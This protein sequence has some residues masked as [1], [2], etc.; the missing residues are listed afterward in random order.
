MIVAS[1][2]NGKGTTVLSVAPDMSVRDAARFLRDK[3]IGATVVLD[4]NRKLVGI[5]SERDVLNSVA[6]RGG[7]AL[8]E[9]LSDIRTGDART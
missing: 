2:L 8:A 7:A 4:V 1:L 6:D 3:H 5:L 9:A